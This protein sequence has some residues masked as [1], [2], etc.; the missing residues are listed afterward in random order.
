MILA[1]FVINSRSK[2]RNVLNIVRITFQHFVIN[3]VY[4]MIEIVVFLNGEKLVI[5][6]IN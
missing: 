1:I 6:K 5:E 4:S 2:R 3:E